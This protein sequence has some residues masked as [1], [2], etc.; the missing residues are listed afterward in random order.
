MEADVKNPETME[1]VTG[2]GKEVGEVM[3]RG[4]TVMS[5]YLKDIE[6][7]REVFRGGWYRTGDVA[8]KHPDGYLELKD[9]I[10]DVII[11]GGESVS[12]IKVEAVLYEHPAVFEAAVVARP[13]DFLGEIPCAFVKLKA[14]LA[15]TEEEIIGFVK[16]RL[17]HY[18]APS[19]VVF[20]D[21]PRT[22]TGKVQKYILKDKAIAMAT[23]VS[24]KL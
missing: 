17:P 16:G 3:F 21:L 11:T 24:A 8:V 20:Q 12:S 19:T 13:D 1:S 10:K 6:R 9:R 14:G 5:G 18:M 7:T 15:A 22:S 4:N 23:L 2:D